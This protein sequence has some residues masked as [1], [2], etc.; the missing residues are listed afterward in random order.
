MILI[1]SI[2]I[3]VI[4]SSSFSLRLGYLY[5]P[6]EDFVWA[7]FG[8]PII[9]IPIFYS[10]RMYRIVVRYI[11][12]G[13][14]W[15]V[16]QAISLYSVIWGLIVYL[17]SI[18]LSSEVVRGVLGSVILINWML[19]IIVIGGLRLI[20]QWIF[21][22]EN[23]KKNVIIY[24]A[25]S[26]GSQ[27]SVALTQSD[28]FKVICF[29][30]DSIVNQMHSID[31]IEI[32]SPK[33]LEKIITQKNISEILIAIPSLSRIRRREIIKS[34]ESYPVLVRSLPSVSELVRGELKI[35]D[36]RRV[37]IKDLL[38][39]ETVKP[40]NSLLKLKITD[41]VV[42]VTGAGGSIGSEL[43]RQI[44]YL[45]PKKLI[46][47][48]VSEPALYQIEQQLTEI[49]DHNVEILGVLGSVR[50]YS[51]LES[52]FTQ[53]SVQT[54]YHA[55]AY[56]HVPIVE[57]NQSE[58]VLNNVIGT[59]RAAEAAIKAKVQTFVLVSTDKAVRPTNTMGATKRVS[60][61]VLQAL[62]KNKHN[63][64][65]TMVRFGNVLDSSGSVIPL[66]KKQIESGGPVTV[67]DKKIVR[68]FMTV[69]EAVELVIQ[70]G[71]MGKGGDVFVL[72]MGKPVLINDLAK[73]IIHLSGLQVKDEN[74]PNGDIEIKYV[75]LRPGEKLFEELLVGKNVTKTENDLIMRA[76]EIM[77]D[78]DNLKPTLTELEEVSTKFQNNR[79]RE[80][81]IQLVPEFKPK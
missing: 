31:G 25:G 40:N 29:I 4:L 30:D 56:K 45:K 71:A 55:A 37:D 76:E 68:Y 47:F 75:G 63:T 79:I 38:G 48:E 6:F 14:L 62:S 52:I 70:A 32:Y 12:L 13:S 81:L 19:S 80:V 59:W 33:F 10:F 72:D 3:V 20:A 69:Q 41:K 23:I 64:Y 78:W 11:G 39:R 8:A 42:L 60:E 16:I 46:L 57:N 35:E 34:L 22:S 74:N 1:D 21:S 50:Y 44:I 66:F 53:H 7:I 54:V 15:E 27:L 49:S 5:F 77:I 18:N 24:G 17:V 67:T 51:K 36:L 43:S 28:E 65:F 2:A 73:K 61:L 9:A 26:A 58:G